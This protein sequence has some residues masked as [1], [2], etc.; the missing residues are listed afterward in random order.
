MAFLGSDKKK[1]TLPDVPRAWPSRRNTNP[2]GE[3]PCSPASPP[4]TAIAV[5]LDDHPS[6][7]MIRFSP[8]IR[9]ASELVE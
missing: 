5:T 7:R 9:F 6:R 2:S 1:T 8:Y 3:I 4:R